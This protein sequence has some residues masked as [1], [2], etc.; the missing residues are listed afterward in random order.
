MSIFCS[1]RSPAIG[2]SSASRPFHADGTGADGPIALCEAQA[3]VFAAK[4]SAARLADALGRPD[5]GVRLAAE[6]EKLRARFE[7]T[8]WCDEIGTYALAL[9]GKKRPCR[10]RSSNAGH[11]L[12][13]GIAVPERARILA[14]TL[15]SADSFSGRGIRTL[16]RGEPRYNPMSYHNGSIWP[17]DNAS[18]PPG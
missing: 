11:A 1:A 7:E 9:D 17:H 10:V 18:S 6:A 5:L 13:A 2:P 4:R 8:F 14:K 12:F 15:M 16:A 3:N